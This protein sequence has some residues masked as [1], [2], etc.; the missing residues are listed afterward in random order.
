MWQRRMKEHNSKFSNSFI[1]FLLIDKQSQ[2]PNLA[3]A[4]LLLLELNVIRN[5]FILT[6]ASDLVNRCCYYLLSNRHPNLHPHY[7]SFSSKLSVSQ[8][9]ISKIYSYHPRSLQFCSHLNLLSINDPSDI[10]LLFRPLW[11]MRYDKNPLSLP[12]KMFLTS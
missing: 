10:S 8:N 7:P 12:R 4:I 2:I 1:Y 6:N 5:S 3:L 9:C 11:Q